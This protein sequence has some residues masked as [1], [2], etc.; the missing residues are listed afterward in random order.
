M[1]PSVHAGDTHSSLFTF[2]RYLPLVRFRLR[3]TDRSFYDLFSVTAEHLVSG[4]T[5]LAQVLDEDA[6]LKALAK[7]I[8][9]IEHAADDSTHELVRKVNAAFVTPFDREDIYALARQLDDVMDYMEQAADQIQLYR[10]KSFPEELIAQVELIQRCAEL[11]AGAMPRL[12]ALSDLEEYWLEVNRL[13]KAGDR[14]HR[15]IIAKLFSGDYKA[16]EVLK[17]KDIAE[18]VEGAL[19]AFEDVANTV[20]T[21]SVKES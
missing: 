4:A 15:R 14:N 13:E 8:H 20:E 2:V 19:N 16:L 12:Q 3:P 11:T 7:Q 9:D 17:L 10:V 21:I 5:L 6:D 18:S 1:S